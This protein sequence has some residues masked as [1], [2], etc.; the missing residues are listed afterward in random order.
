MAE[1]GPEKEKRSS[2]RK[3]P[4]ETVVTGLV[5]AVVFGFLYAANPKDWWWIFPAVFGGVLPMIGGIRRLATAK[6]DRQNVSKEM[7]A[8]REREALKAARDLNGR[9]TAAALVLRTDLSIKEAQTALEDLAR[10]GQASMNVTSQG[11]I[12][13]LFPS[14]LPPLESDRPGVPVERKEEK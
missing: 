12:E 6:L 14:F 9:V 13:F 5:I 3:K 4:M 10:E 11:V 8:E 1:T 2:K 7:E